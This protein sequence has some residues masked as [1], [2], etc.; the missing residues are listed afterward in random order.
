ME[1]KID[2]DLLDELMNT[3]EIRETSTKLTPEELA[4]LKRLLI[5]TGIYEQYV[6]ERNGRRL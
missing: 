2:Q 3:P 6:K 1:N 4:W 5:S